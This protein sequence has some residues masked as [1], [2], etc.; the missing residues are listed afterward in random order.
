MKRRRKLLALGLGAA[1]ALSLSLPCFAV[2]TDTAYTDVASDAWYADAVD[3]VRE[4]G[5]MQGT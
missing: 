1:L 4:N 5:L 3:Y 2:P